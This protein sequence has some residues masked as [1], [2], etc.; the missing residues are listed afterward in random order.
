MYGT[1][2]PRRDKAPCEEWDLRICR[3]DEKGRVMYGV[4]VIERD[5]NR[6]IK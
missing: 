1:L 5:S 2:V 6:D 4:S 3:P